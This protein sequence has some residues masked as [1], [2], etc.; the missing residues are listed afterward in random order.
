MLMSTTLLRVRV[1]SAHAR[2]AKQV[3]DNLGLRPADAVGALFAQIAARRGLPFAVEEQ[4]YGY[5]ESEYGLTPA[6]V[7]R[8]EAAMRREVERERRRGRL[9]KRLVR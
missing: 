8:A 7:D 4:G 6:E 5:A 1:N 9:L 3:L 2:R